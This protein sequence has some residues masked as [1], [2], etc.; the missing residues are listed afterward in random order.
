MECIKKRIKKIKT[1]TKWI[2]EWAECTN[3]IVQIIYKN[4]RHILKYDYRF[5]ACKLI[6]FLLEYFFGRFTS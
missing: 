4:G 3:I 2:M 5:F 6:H 1:N